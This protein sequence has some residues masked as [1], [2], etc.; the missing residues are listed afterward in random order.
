MERNHKSCY[1]RVHGHP[2]FGESSAYHH[3]GRIHLP[4]ALRCNIKC[5]YCVRKHDCANENRPGLTSR[6][7]NPEEAVNR[8][9][10]VLA[11]E[12]RIRVVAVAGPGDALANPASFETLRLV[13]QEFPDLI[14]CMSSNGL[15]LLDSLDSLLKA[16]VNHLTITINAIEKNIGKHIYSWVRY[17]GQTFF[18][19]DAFEILSARQIE[20]LRAAVGEGIMVKVNSVLIPGINDEHLIKVA[21]VVADQGAHVMNIMKLIPQAEFS[22]WPAPSDFELSKVQHQCQFFIRQFRG[23][24]QCRADAVGFL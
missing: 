20:G 7:I 4:V 5:K 17:K 18:G 8:V 2:C 3:S 16:G 21:Q 22:N 14:K 15:L 1:Q 10:E 11:K 12:P 19:E 13:H 6:I 24:R 9:R 23:C